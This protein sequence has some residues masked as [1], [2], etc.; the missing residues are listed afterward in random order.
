MLSTVGHDSQ[1]LENNI[2]VNLKSYLKIPKPTS[3]SAANLLKVSD[4]NACCKREIK[5]VNWIIG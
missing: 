2:K 3:Q 5:F 1:I 4:Y